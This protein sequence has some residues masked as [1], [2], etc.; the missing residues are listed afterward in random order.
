MLEF[1]DKQLGNYRTLRLLGEGGLLRSILENMS[2]SK[3]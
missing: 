1:V 2:I 3:Q